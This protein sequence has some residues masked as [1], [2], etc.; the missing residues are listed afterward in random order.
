[1]LQGDILNRKLFQL[2]FMGSGLATAGFLVPYSLY[3]NSDFFGWSAPRGGEAGVAIGVTLAGVISLITV[4]VFIRFGKGLVAALLVTSFWLGLLAGFVAPIIQSRPYWALS[5]PSSP[6]ETLKV[7]RVAHAG[8]SIKGLVYTNSLEALELNKERFN[9]FEIDLMQLADGSV[10]CLHDL[11]PSAELHFGAPLDQL[12]S[13]QEF[14]TLRK[15]NPELTPCSL[16]ELAAWF[17]ANPEKYLVTDAKT[18]NLPLLEELAR[19][20]PDL[21]G[22]TIPQI[23]FFDEYDAVSKLGFENQIFTTYKSR[24]SAADIVS[25]SREL[26][27]FA[28]TLAAEEIG[29]LTQ[30]LSASG[31]PTYVH[32]VNDLVWYSKIREWGVSNIYTDFLK[33]TIDGY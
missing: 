1:M 32:T 5:A 15:F 9:F 31:V 23:Y 26:R 27:F 22:Q 28:V 4:G 11:G 2:F 17:G 19:T 13:Q 24:P 14:L 3:L 8:G 18:E 6:A 7:P 20:H 16:E 33:A 12:T 29:A 21:V 10:V 30:D 25:A